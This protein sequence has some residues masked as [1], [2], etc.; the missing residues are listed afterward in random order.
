MNIFIRDST[1]QLFKFYDKIVTGN[2]DFLDYDSPLNDFGTFS[3]IFLR[4]ISIFLKADK[5]DEEN[6]SKAIEEYKSSLADELEITQNNEKQKE[7]I[8]HVTGLID[9]YNENPEGTLKELNEIAESVFILFSTRMKRAQADLKILASKNKDAKKAMT[10]IDD[11]IAKRLP[12]LNV[13]NVDTSKIDPLLINTD[14]CVM[15]KKNLTKLTVVFPRC[16]CTDLATVYAV[17]CSCPCFCK[18]CW[19]LEMS[20]NYQKCPRCGKPVQQF[21]EIDLND[22]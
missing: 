16:F 9:K 22:E 5:S 17:P 6:L 3:N 20:E 13:T 21:V 10:E 12:K 2:K 15:M 19:E 8:H 7:L 14:S 4:D 1:P 11:Y 18:Q